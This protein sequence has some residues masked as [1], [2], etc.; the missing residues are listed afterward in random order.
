MDEIAS[1]AGI[2]KPI[3]YRHFGDKDGL[4]E[5]LAQRYVDQLMD[6]LDSGA[7]T[8]DARTRLAARIDAYL[9]YV[10]QNPERYRFILGAAELPGT[11]AIV[12]DFRQRRA[13]ACAARAAESLRRAGLDSELAEPWAHAVCGMIRSVGIWWLETRTLP[14]ASLVEYLTALLWDG[15]APLRRPAGGEDDSRVTPR[16]AVE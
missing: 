8:G 16:N 4:Y 14:R 15:F 12:A 7:A 5:A 10:E 13:N 3:L 1:E 2:T 9:S 11:S 6:E